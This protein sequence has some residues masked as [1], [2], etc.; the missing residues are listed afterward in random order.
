MSGAAQEWAVDAIGGMEYNCFLV[1]HIIVDYGDAVYL[2]RDGDDVTVKDMLLQV[3]S[4][5]TTAKTRTLSKLTWNSGAAG[6]SFTR[7][8][9][10]INAIRS[11][12]SLPIMFSF[13]FQRTPKTAC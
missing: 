3:A 7:M 10:P 11:T 9:M 8:R 13:D 5:C 12:I 1:D 2:V 6:P 4:G